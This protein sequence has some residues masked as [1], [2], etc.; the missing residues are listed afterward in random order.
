MSHTPGPWRVDNRQVKAESPSIGAVVAEVVTTFS[1]NTIRAEPTDKPLG[2][3]ERK[4]YVS[5]ML[6]EAIAQVEGDE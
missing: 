3:T 5:D 2:T 6:S 1:G 4:E